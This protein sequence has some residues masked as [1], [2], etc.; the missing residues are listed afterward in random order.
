MKS[1][2]RKKGNEKMS[3]VKCA[4]CDSTG[5][6]WSLCGGCRKVRYCSKD[7]QRAH[8][9]THSAECK[10]ELSSVLDR[11]ARTVWRRNF[12]KELDLDVRPVESVATEDDDAVTVRLGTRSFSEDGLEVMKRSICNGCSPALFWRVHQTGSCNVFVRGFLLFLVRSLRRKL[13]LHWNGR[14]VDHVSCLTV[15]AR[16]ALSHPQPLTIHFPSGRIVRSQDFGH[17]HQ[18]ACLNLRDGGSVWIDLSPAQ[19]FQHA[20]D[21]LHGDSILTEWMPNL[22]TTPPP[23]SPLYSQNFRLTPD[24]PRRTVPPQIVNDENVLRSGCDH[25]W[26]QIEAVAGHFDSCR[27][28]VE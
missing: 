2:I 18:L 13:R 3:K 5:D 16:H 22:V 25:L 11:W 10:V 26:P 27:N 12:L 20:F 17:L 24:G 15:S 4:N 1:P 21:A 8:W 23:Y 6:G 28:F 7:C 9:S 19:H 14:S